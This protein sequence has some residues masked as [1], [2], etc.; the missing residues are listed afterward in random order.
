MSHALASP[1][2]EEGMSKQQLPAPGV[3]LSARGL[4]SERSKTNDVPTWT[5]DVTQGLT[6]LLVDRE[7]Q[8]TAGILTLTGRRRPADGEVRLYGRE[9]SWTTPRA[10]FRRCALAGAS[11]IDSLDRLVPAKEI[12]REQLAWA[13]PWWKL[14]PKRAL[15]HPDVQPWLEIFGLTEEH[16]CD[17]HQA[18]GDL[19]VGD[20]FTLRI[21][22]ALIARPHAALLAVDDIDQV[23]NLDIRMDILEKL[24][25][26]AR[27]LP[28][29]VTTVNEDAPARDCTVIDARGIPEEHPETEEPA[30]EDPE[31]E[32]E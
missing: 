4:K 13:L 31:A 5:F 20:R 27:V 19:D 32:E 12:I 25:E 26:V 17:L 21:A 22:L 10:L 8:A 14:T 3:V 23:R 1:R 18:A 29:V 2:K 24:V 28:V 16:G 7:S 15:E 11:E 9:T 30:A 6:M